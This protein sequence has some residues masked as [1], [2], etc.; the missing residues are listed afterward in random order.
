M[1]VR[2]RGVER[3]TAALL[4]ASARPE[5]DPEGVQQALR[6][7][8]DLDRA[9]RRA[10]VGRTAPLL[11]RALGAVEASGTAAVAL[12][13]LREEHDLRRAQ[14]LVLVPD[15]LQ[16]AVD[17]L[18][19]EG[20]EPLVVKGPVVADRYPA[21]GLRPM[22]DIDVI[23]PAT[24]HQ[25]ALAA[26]DRAGWREHVRPGKHHD[27]VLLHAAAPG[28]ALEV[29]RSLESWRDRAHGLS[30]DDLWRER[31]PRTCMGIDVF[32]L[33]P[34]LELLAL[35]VHAGKP[36]HTFQRLIWS[37]DFAVVVQAAGAD[38]DWDDLARRA[39]AAKAWTAV[40]VGLQHARRLGADVPD[41]LLALPP[42]RFRRAS[43][44]PVVDERWVLE[45]GVGE[46]H[47]L[48]YALWDG[49]LARA[50]LF[51]GE[52]TT[53]GPRHVPRRVAEVLGLGLR[54]WW[55]WRGLSSAPGQGRLTP[56]GE[57][58]L[59]AVAKARLATE[60]VGT[61]ARARVALRSDDLPAAFV[62][63]RGDV[64]TS[65]AAIPHGDAVRLGRVVE[66]TLEALRLDTRCLFLSAVLTAMLS[67]RGTPSTV[68]IGV[69]PGDEF[70]A[71]AWVELSGRPILRPA[72]DGFT[73][74]VEL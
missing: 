47:R 53:A 35:I 60:V 11:W 68:V 13:A 52:V 31:I 16:R 12:G 74:L 9:A 3:A 27:T 19:D 20:L 23:L 18:R 63:L 50:R 8:A 1:T 43:L 30:A 4:W 42:G 36:H 66:R 61:Y 38:L 39:R 21:V 67:R 29:H 7:G 6:D 59:G 73:R 37:V 72:E 55:R 17:P 49:R 2:D 10:L 24:D 65:D 5:P 56:T 25:R 15:A 26:L 70:G 40:A 14:A 54:R 45:R 71:H 28:L 41:E 64:P 51:A 62:R 57:V 48:R 22:D 46:V 58:E 44:Q 34:A 32:S 33:P 69:R